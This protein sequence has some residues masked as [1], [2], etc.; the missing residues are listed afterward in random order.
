MR[1]LY[2]CADRGIP[3][4]GDKGAS[5]HVRQ[6]VRAMAGMGM[7]VTVLAART[8][9]GWSV[10]CRV[11][12]RVPVRKRGVEPPA[13]TRN[14]DTLAREIRALAE[15][16]DLVDNVPFA[17]GDID[18]IYERYSLWSLAG[19]A[20]SE[21][22]Q[23]PLVLEVN[24]PLPEEQARYRKLILEKTAIE[25]E[26]LLLRRADIVLC[27]SSSLEQRATEIRGTDRGVH[28]FP[29][30]VDTELFRPSA[31]DDVA[32]EDG[33]PT[34]IFTG[35]LKPWHGLPLL[36]EAFARLCESRPRSRLVIVGEGPE[37]P[38]LMRQVLEKGVAS[39]VEF[40][41]SVPHDEVPSLLRRATIA[42]APYPPMDNF[43]FSPLKLAEYLA[44]GLPVVSSRCGDLSGLLRH[45]RSALLVPPGDV[46][47]LSEA[48]TELAG[49][50]ELRARLGSEGRR[51]ATGNLSLESSSRRLRLLLEMVSGAEA[52]AWQRKAL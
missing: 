37:R 18:L 26:G 39:R 10:P 13:A 24:A 40:T 11:L 5:V 20:L 12:E 50:P 22:L 32:P 1:I 25:I 33:D 36:V 2:V 43:Y 38:R 51:L 28:L 30:S 48:L 35:T 17:A 3:L 42:V 21:R 15:S 14:S 34:I 4:D 23:V 8:G 27:V 6:T 49:D 16:R 7:E 9:N 41:G 29:N 45:R 19:A 52:Q 31:E 44:S 47:A 46:Q